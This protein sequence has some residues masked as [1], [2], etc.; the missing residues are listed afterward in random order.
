MWPLCELT[1]WRD[2]IVRKASLRVIFF[3]DLYQDRNLRAS[4][5]I[6]KSSFAFLSFFILFKQANVNSTY[7]STK[8][9]L[10][11][12][13]ICFFLFFI[14][15]ETRKTAFSILNF[16]K[17]LT[18]YKS[19]IDRDQWSWSTKALLFKRKWKGKKKKV[20]RLFYPCIFKRC[21]S[22]AEEEE[23]EEEEEA[24]RE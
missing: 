13:E 4:S 19:A 11:K 5:I 6:F 10:I 22:I 20:R 17:K 1:H 12:H 21:I 7:L 3:G 18:K 14:S 15:K 23:E 24:H 2:R 9:N 16:L 8:K